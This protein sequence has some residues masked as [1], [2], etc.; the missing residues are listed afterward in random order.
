MSNDAFF[1]ALDPSSIKL[2]GPF[3]RP[4]EPPRRVPGSDTGADL[5]SYV[6]IAPDWEAVPANATTG[7]PSPATV[8]RIAT[9]PYARL[10]PAQLFA[11]AGVALTPG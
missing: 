10:L 11:A 5:N 8:A 4:I 3:T 7:S 2:D 1:T 6:T 9:T